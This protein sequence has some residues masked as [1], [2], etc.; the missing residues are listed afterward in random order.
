MQLK[1]NYFKRDPNNACGVSD[2]NVHVSDKI[3]KYPFNPALIHQVIS[4]YLINSRQ[5]SKAQKSRSEVIGS[6]KK[7]WRQKGTGRARSGSV[8]S[9]IWRSGGV[10]FA[11]KPKKYNQKINKKMYRGAI[12][13]ILSKLV[14]DNR[15]LLIEDLF[16]EKPKTKFLLER[17]GKMVSKKS[18]LIIT[19]VIDNN[20]LLSSRNLHKV[21]ILDLSHI[22]PVS[23]VNFD[24]TLIM[25]SAVHDLEQKLI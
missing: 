13:S 5:G 6:N 3:F 12:K 20:V 22:N 16:L 14:C 18:V 11:S 10:T 19:N 8:K 17:I 25:Q 2:I 1:I 7:P 23:L 4:S 15:L 24:I 21:S 9:P